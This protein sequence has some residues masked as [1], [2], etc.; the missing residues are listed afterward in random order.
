MPQ[1]TKMQPN[2]R[3]AK[4][5]DEIMARK[6]KFTE[7]DRVKKAVITADAT[8]GLLNMQKYERVARALD[9]TNKGRD[10]L[11]ELYSEFIDPINLKLFGI[12]YSI[13]GQRLDLGFGDNMLPAEKPSEDA[14]NLAIKE[15]S[16]FFEKMSNDA[17]LEGKTNVKAFILYPLTISVINTWRRFDHEFVGNLIEKIKSKE[18]DEYLKRIIGII[19]IP[20]TPLR[21]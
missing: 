3:F 8:A 10:S 2:E 4:L 19:D 6:Y 5:E 13:V 14:K 20:V 7:Y 11:G 1:V 15:F 9:L 12:R 16:D 21:K 17:A 18:P